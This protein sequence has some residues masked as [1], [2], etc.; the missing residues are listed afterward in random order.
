[1]RPFSNYG[2]AIW[3]KSPVDHHWY[4]IKKP[5][6]NAKVVL[7][8]DCAEN[9]RI[10]RHQ[11]QTTLPAQ[12]GWQDYSYRDTGQIVGSCTALVKC[13]MCSVKLSHTTPSR[14][15]ILLLNISRHCFQH[16]GLRRPMPHTGLS[17]DVFD[18]FMRGPHR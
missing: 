5:P 6:H 17:V 10:C 1:M 14:L 12:A 11:R 15:M 7:S 16:I 4:P 13:Y 3:C 2:V 9:R 8:L 18:A